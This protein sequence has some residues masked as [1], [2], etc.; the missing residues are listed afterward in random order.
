MLIK[1]LGPV[2]IAKGAHDVRLAG[3]AQRALVAA[4]A[5]RRGGVV[6]VSMLAEAIWDG[7]PPATA[8]T[9]IQAHVSALRRALG[10]PTRRV[11]GPLL[12]IESGYAFCSACVRL[13]LVAFDEFAAKGRTAF[14]VG[15]P[16][17]ASDLFGAALALWR[18]EV[19]AELSSPA[20]RAAAQPLEERRLLAIE[21]KAEADLALRRPE[22]VVAE[23]STWLVTMPLRERL[24]GLVMLAQY[25]LG[26]RAAALSTYREGHRIM[27][28]EAGLEPGPQ[29]RSLHQQL[30]ADDPALFQSHAIASSQAHPARDGRRAPV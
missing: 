13:D 5:L 20:L 21:A 9:K 14:D 3:Q 24:R 23:L 30:L 25:R 11:C 1:I 8:R 2:E 17:A 10:Q 6:P 16:G 26:C 15:D 27:V 22:V 29:L 12:T 28:A 7:V 19:F 18:G 4:L